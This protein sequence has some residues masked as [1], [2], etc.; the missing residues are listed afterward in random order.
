[1]GDNLHFSPRT[2]ANL[3]WIIAIVLTSATVISAEPTLDLTVSPDPVTV[4]DRFPV[5]VAARGADDGLWGQLEVT[6]SDSGPWAV[7]DSPRAVAGTHPP[8]WTAVLAP[9]GVGE[10]ELPEMSVVLRSTDGVATTVRPKEQVIV[11]VTSV[12]PAEGEAEPAPLR[13]PVGIEGFPWE[14]IGPV[15]AVVIPLVVLAWWWWRRRRSDDP[16]VARDLPPLAELERLIADLEK[17]IGREP[18]EGVCDRLA[19]GLRRYVERRCGHPAL[20]MTSF[21]LR[22]LARRDG[23]PDAVQRAVQRVMGVADGIRFGRRVTAE[24]DLREAVDL[25]GAAA[26]GIENFLMPEVSEDEKPAE[27]AS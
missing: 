13:D 9:L 4:G 11:T 7:L 24:A 18:A 16:F 6:V 23:W 12:L 22:V 10:V 21:E 8:V 27:V 15:A 20:E 2:V 19:T 14:W 5:R 26:R 17:S 3:V 1:V 25:A